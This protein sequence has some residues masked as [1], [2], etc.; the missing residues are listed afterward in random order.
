MS[1][2]IENYKGFQIDESFCIFKHGKIVFNA[3]WQ[4]CCTMDEAKMLIDISL[5]KTELTNYQ[6]RQASKYGNI[7]QQPIINP[8]GSCELENG[9][10]EMERF[11][12]WNNSM[13]EN[14]LYE[15]SNY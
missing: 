10:E 1:T 5:A 12:E 2:N 13:A 11:A 15:H 8:D 14:E 3:Y 4:F 6:E 9:S 7:L